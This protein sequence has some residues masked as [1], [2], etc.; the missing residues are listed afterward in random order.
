MREGAGEQA[1]GKVYAANTIG[2]I[3]GVLFAIHLMLP[4]IGTK[5]AVVVAAAF[6][7]VIALL[8]LRREP[9]RTPHP[10]FTGCA[11]RER[12]GHS[13]C[14]CPGETRP[15]PDGFRCVPSWPAR[16]LPPGAE[17]YLPARWQNRDHHAHEA[18]R[19][20]IHRHQRKTRRGVEHVRRGR[21]DRSMR[22][23]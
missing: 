11:R 4:F 17:V 9:R 7:L 2:A 21:R 20:G 23:R 15:E 1:I 3:A 13:Q 12:G 10:F 8:L 6:Q 5:G 19:R 22:S 14:R 18:R 16:S